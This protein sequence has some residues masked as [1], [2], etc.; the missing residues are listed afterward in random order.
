M[1]HILVL[2]GFLM[3]SNFFQA[4]LAFAKNCKKG[5]PCG[6][7]CISKEDV[8]HKESGGSA[9]AAPGPAPTT[10]TNAPSTTSPTAN[11]T[12]TTENPTNAKVCKKGKPCGNS[13]I[14]EKAVCHP[15]EAK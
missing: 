9:V 10:S 13:C 2:V 6:N 12:T 4:D 1:K 8:C 5:K 7:A 11:V 14:S 15:R 3:V